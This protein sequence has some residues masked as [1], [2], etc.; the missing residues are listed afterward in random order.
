MNLIKGIKGN[1][2]KAHKIQ[3]KKKTVGVG[4][5]QKTEGVENTFI[6]NKYDPAFQEN[7]ADLSA[8]NIS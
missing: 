7:A 6:I 1:R 2:K 8:V 5:C 3:K 4:K